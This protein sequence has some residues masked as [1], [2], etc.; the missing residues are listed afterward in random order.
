MYTLGIDLST[1]SLTLS[2]LNYKTKTNE[3]NISVAFSEI[4][5]TE[6]S[7][8]NRKTLLIDSDIEGKAEQDPNI[9][10]ISLE[11][12]FYELK[13]KCDIKKIKAIQISAQQHGHVYLSER[14]KSALK[15][16]KDKNNINEKLVDIIKT[17][18][19]YPNVPIW[20]TSDTKKEAFAI[21]EKIGGKKKII[22]I[23]GSD[24]PL[25]FTGAIIKKTFE[26]DKVVCQN[27]YK[28]FLLNTFLASILSA[29][30]NVSF[31][32]GNAS[33]T[34]LMDYS[35]KEWDDKLLNI[36]S[37]SLNLKLND[38]KSPKSKAGNIANHFVYKYGFDKNCI[39][40]IGSG[41]NPETKVL[42]KGDVLSLG[43][44]FVYMLNI[45]DSQRDYSGVSN[46]MYDG[47]G[48][49]FMIFCRTNGAM[50]WDEIMNKYNKNYRDVTKSLKEN[51][52]KLPLMLWQKEEESVPLSKAFD[53]KRY[54][55]DINFDNDY[56][57]IILSSLSL[58]ES[59]SSGF[60]KPK[61]LSVTGGA[62]KDLE[63]LKIIANIWQCTINILPAGGASLGAALAAVLLIDNNISIIEEIRENLREKTTIEPETSLIDK[64]ENYKK[65][66]KEK[67][68]EISR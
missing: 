54:Y 11:K 15:K 8:M 53:M 17:S 9:F 47:L 46:S 52:S 5:K 23:T 41:D 67:F 42:S 35:K 38:I 57:A 44:S 26:E 55:N 50:L 16:L 2:L 14:F 58:V 1:Q 28:V 22:E 36:C 18:Y 49:P 60:Q 63:I 19:S 34:S 21:R 7:S 59:Y 66:M 68:E 29:E 62:T 51:T 61:N 48:N 40:G 4:L 27:T 37:D 39:V 56:K 33:G 31:D 24:S 3:L 65:S 10:L 25:R 13:N 20:R 12:L 43:T 64:Y 30:E 45:D 32:Y 6:S